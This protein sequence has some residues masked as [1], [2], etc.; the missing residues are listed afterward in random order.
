MRGALIRCTTSSTCLDQ[1]V[2]VNC[3]LSTVTLVPMD[4]RDDTTRS[5]SNLDKLDD[6]C[7]RQTATNFHCYFKSQCAVTTLIQRPSCLSASHAK[8]CA[9]CP[10]RCQPTLQCLLRLLSP[11]SR[12]ITVKRT[13]L[14]TNR[15]RYR[16][17][18]TR[19]HSLYL[20]HSTTTADLT[21]GKAPRARG[22]VDREL[23]VWPPRGGSR[24]YHVVGSPNRVSWTVTHG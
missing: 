8:S 15:L 3:Q 1:Q 20:K 5:A 4:C 14:T 11:F 17:V 13:P 24:G 6:L 12:S 2:T 22:C 19:A 16:S 23:Q 18:Y 9:G 21:T 10:R 7:S